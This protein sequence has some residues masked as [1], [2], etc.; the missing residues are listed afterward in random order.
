VIDSLRRCG[1]SPAHTLSRTDIPCRE[2]MMIRGVSVFRVISARNTEL[3]QRTVCIV[4]IYNEAEVL[5]GVLENIL[6]VFPNVL[7][8]DDGSDDGSAEIAAL[9]GARVLRHVLNIGQGG[10]LHTAFK[11]IAQES[12]FDYVVTYDADGQHRP[13]DALAAL[14]KLVLTDADIVFASRFWEGGTSNVPMLKRLL[15]KSVVL[16]NR[17]ITDVDLTDTH[18][19]LR[20]IRVSVLQGIPINHF[21]MAHATE[22]VSRSIQSGLQY[23]EVPVKIEYTEYS[24]RKGQSL[25]NSVNIVLDFLWR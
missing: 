2:A 8:V 5:E 18:N 15:L 21:G 20:A 14:Q 13:S 10:A 25:L 22:I 24:K 16:F 4:P 12:K 23:A 1:R 19:G 9:C 6:Q 17:L 3:C 7:C 11:V